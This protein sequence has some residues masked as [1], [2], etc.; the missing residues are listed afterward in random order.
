LAV[1]AAAQT[2]R[3]YD[4]DRSVPFQYQEET[5]RRD[6]RVEMAGAGFQSHKRGKVNLVVVR[7]TGQGPFA[8]IVYQHGGGQSMQTYLAEAEVLAQAGAIS[9]ILDAPGA[10][11]GAPKPP[12][13]RGAAMREHFVELTVCYR[14]AVDYLET[15]KTVDPKRIAFVGHSYGGISGAALVAVEPRIRTFVL[16]GAVARMT[17]HV[18]EADIEPWITWRKDLSPGQLSSELAQF[19]AIDPD[20]FIL[21]PTHGP[22]FFQCGNFDFINVQ[23]CLDLTAAASAPK[24]L[25]WYDTDHPFA[26][27]EATLDR[28]RWLETQLHLKP[29]RSLL[30]RLWTAPQKRSTPLQ[31][32]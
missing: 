3:L 17:R 23:P 24:E 13:G 25:R 8:A 31:A 2:S 21:A 16:I 12:D 9:L 5:L 6:A 32:K 28:L 14:R 19:R 7:P 29:V 15:L 30:D 26:D 10:G 18:G 11:P 22:V 1:T 4:Y 27:L 20:N